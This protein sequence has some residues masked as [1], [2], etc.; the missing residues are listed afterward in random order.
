LQTIRSSERLKSEQR[1]QREQ[2]EGAE[3]GRSYGQSLNE[4]GQMT[5]AKVSSY[6]RS[7]NGEERGSLGRGKTN[8]V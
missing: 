7:L 2:K 6:G 3:R 8:A 5:D 1:R 4:E